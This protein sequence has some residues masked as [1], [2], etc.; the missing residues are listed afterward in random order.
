MQLKF[1]IEI[2]IR[3]LKYVGQ[4]IRSTR[5][6]LM[7]IMLQGKAELK[8]NKGWQ[9]ASLNQQFEGHQWPKIKLNY[10]KK[11]GQSILADCCGKEGCSN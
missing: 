8:R 9:P 11:K 4:A 6:D 1:L 10:E 5:T 3:K 7:A 2:N